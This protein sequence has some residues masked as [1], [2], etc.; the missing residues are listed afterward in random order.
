MNPI[1]ELSEMDFQQA[2]QDLKQLATT[3]ESAIAGQTPLITQ[4][5]ITFIAGGHILLEGL[6]GLGKTHLAKAMAA[7]TDLGFSRIQCTPDLMPA[8][9]TGS[10]ILLKGQDGQQIL[11]FQPGPVFSQMVLV[12]EINRATPKTQSALLEAMQE[13]Q[14]TFSGTTH[15]LN[16]PF[17]V[18]A[19]Q[20][21]IEIEGT[22][23]LPEAQL[24][25][26]TTKL[27]VDF[28]DPEAL[29]TMLDISL[30]SEPSEQLKPC[31]TVQRL[32]QIMH[33]SREILVSDNIKQ[34]AVQ[35]LLS[36]HPGNKADS[37][38]FRYGASPR[39]LQSLIRTA[40]VHAL[41]QDRLQVDIDDLEAM[42]MPTLRHRVL[43]SIESELAGIDSDE[44]LN[45]LIKSWR[46]NV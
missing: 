12:D 15:P 16:S 27:K 43:L 37:N 13:H 9:I 19:T 11:K 45:H 42:A 24:D 1:N 28:P 39:G 18:I 40:R 4:M 17:W 3:L 41:M 44:L 30:D 35:L 21:P 2:R 10:E 25:R 31:L 23:P 34:A 7:I 36:T 20:N 29:L 14:V 38:H 32:K 8:D 46:E 22:Y 26:F 5:L 33:L 6:P